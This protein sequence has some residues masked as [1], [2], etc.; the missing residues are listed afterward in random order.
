[1]VAASRLSWVVKAPVQKVVTPVSV[2]DPLAVRD[3]PVLPLP[4]FVSRKGDPANT[5]QE[6][7]CARPEQLV[8]DEP[9]P[10]LVSTKSRV[11]PW[12]VIN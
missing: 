2:T 10:R 11:V 7:P 5:E 8:L 3:T 1:M 12:N 9:G 6:A 4:K